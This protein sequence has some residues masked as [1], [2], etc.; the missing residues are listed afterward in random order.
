MKD[1]HSKESIDRI[2][3]ILFGGQIRKY[4]RRFEQLDKRIRKENERLHDFTAQQINNLLA[5][6]KKEIEGIST[7]L[8]QETHTMQTALKES[9][10]AID[11]ARQELSELKDMLTNEISEVHDKLDDKIEQI[12]THLNRS[13]EELRL[14]L[15]KTSER[16]EANKVDRADLAN[17]FVDM[18]A[19]LKNFKKKLEA[20]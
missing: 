12:N 16:I 20:V 9:T 1:A 2:R 15:K 8:I 18:S 17:M 14:N 6:V 13:H 11:A 10:Q 19:N 3:E 4:E 5:D 7:K